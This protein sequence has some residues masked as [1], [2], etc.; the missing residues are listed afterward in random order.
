MNYLLKSITVFDTHSRYHKKT[1]D[2][3]IEKGK[4]ASIKKKIAAS[5]KTKV[6]N[7]KNWIVLPGLMDI[8][9]RIGEPGNEQREDFDSIEKAAITGGFTSIGIWPDNVPI[10]ETKASANYIRNASKGRAVNFNPIAALTSGLAGKDLSEIYDLN[11]I[12]VHVFSNDYHAIE[13]KDVLSRALHYMLNIDGT[14]LNT[15]YDVKA[16]SET[17]LVEGPLAV[18]MGLDG[19]SEFQEVTAVEMNIKMLDYTKSNLHLWG[20]TEAESMT[21][22]RSAKKKLKGLTCSASLVNLIETEDALRGYNEQFKVYPPLRKTRDVKQLRK[23]ASKGEIDIL[24]ANHHPVESEAKDMEYVH[25]HL[26]MI[27]L[28]TFIP[29]YFMHLKDE[30]SIEQL[31]NMCCYNPR[32]LFKI[33]IPKISVGESAELT[34]IDP[35]ETWNYTKDK[36]ASKSQNTA[37]LDQD[38]VGR[39]KGIFNNNGLYL[40]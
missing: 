3:L 5:G 19:I 2:I 23:S 1:V 14:V 32:S 29:L 12:G 9:V 24:T 28:E 21:M 7:C 22:L 13:D 39:V 4:I 20:V 37:Y 17:A 30:I 38:F 40:A 36:I 31:L 8:S 27:G 6:I 16:I 33:D 18:K 25:S 10:T 15:L 34:F 11:S 35:N 26:G